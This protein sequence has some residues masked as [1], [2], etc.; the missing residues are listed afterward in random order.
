MLN[1]IKNKTPDH[2]ECLRAFIECG[3][4]VWLDARVRRRRVE[5]STYAKGSQVSG[6][7][8][9]Y[10]AAV[11]DEPAEMHRLWNRHQEGAT[12]LTVCVIDSERNDV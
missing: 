6:L 1:Y 7:R 3:S 8:E 2:R 12:G 9:I 5:R 10:T 4:L 11:H